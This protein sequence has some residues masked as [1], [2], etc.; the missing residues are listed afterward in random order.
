M[1]PREASLKLLE[2][3]QIISAVAREIGGHDV[4]VAEF[5]VNTAINALQR[6][7]DASVS[8]SVSVANL[9]AGDRVA[10]LS[11]EEPN[12]TVSVAEY[13]PRSGCIAFRVEFEEIGAM[14]TPGWGSNG[15]YSWGDHFYAAP[16][17]AEAIRARTDLYREAYPEE[18]TA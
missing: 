17:D 1:T 3:R 7:I 15:H 5:D 2:A 9:R 14:H 13:S 6:E 12:L 4:A 10:I 11:G 18:A 8:V 16:A